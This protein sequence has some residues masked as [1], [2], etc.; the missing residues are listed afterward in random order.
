M[1]TRLSE[2]RFARGLPKG[3]DHALRESATDDAFLP[4][5]I[6]R[7]RR[8]G[9]VG[10]AENRLD[11]DRTV[12]VAENP[13]RTRW[14]RWLTYRLTVSLLAREDDA[15]IRFFSISFLA[16]KKTRIE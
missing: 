11:F 13:R 4:G 14:R 7:P 12:V 1:S 5:F 10:L 16:G 15:R 8:T 9:S 2:F 3:T 6:A